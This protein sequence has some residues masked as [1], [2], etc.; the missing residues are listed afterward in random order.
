MELLTMVPISSSGNPIDYRSR[1]LVLGSCFAEHMGSKLEYFQFRNLRNP[2]GIIYQPQAIY[3]L[4]RRS[5][6]RD[7][8]TGEE[9]FKLNERWHCFAVHSDLSNP[10]KEALL[11]NLNQGLDDTASYLQKATHILITLGT[12]WVYR[13]KRTGKLVANCHKVP[14][15]EFQKELLTQAVIT[16]YLDQLSQLLRKR[17]SRIHLTFTVSPV[18]HLRDGFVENQRSKAQLISSVHQLKGVSYFPSYELM[19]DEL[20][21]YRFYTA[22]MVHPNEIAINYIWERFRVSSI[23]A[24]A[25]PI[26]EQVMAIRKG[27]AHRPFNPDSQ[28]HRAFLSS[29]EQKIMV[30]RDSYPFMKF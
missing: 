29:L 30:L 23:A 27:M 20:R 9:L 6:E 22:D 18:R 4:V 8:F 11:Q 21:D 15:R 17:N 25:Y 13:Y 5:L 12:S 10:D 28:T 14:Q 2:F 16:G 19:M 7:Y 24:D 3:E 1:V 26:M